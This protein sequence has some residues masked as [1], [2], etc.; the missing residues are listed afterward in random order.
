[1]KRTIISL[2]FAFMLMLSFSACDDADVSGD[3]SESS[4]QKIS[5]E[6]IY[7]ALMKASEIEST[8]CV[9]TE[10]S[11]NH[12]TVTQRNAD[13]TTDYAE[14]TT[15]KKETTYFDG[16]NLKSITERT[17]YGVTETELTW[18]IKT[19]TGYTMYFISGDDY[20]YSEITNLEIADIGFIAW[21]L[22][23]ILFD[24]ESVTVVEN[25]DEVVYSYNYTIE[26]PFP[27]EGTDRVIVKNGTIIRTEEDMTFATT[28]PRGTQTT[29]STSH[30]TQEIE[31]TDVE[32]ITAPEDWDYENAV[33]MD[34]ADIQDYFVDAFEDVFG[35]S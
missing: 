13:G 16:Q 3:S 20:T 34:W 18:V 24:L 25:G 1:M 17:K 9:F 5:S 6:D 4:T 26:G 22:G 23:D 8:P 32:T 19:E 28:D 21:E 33:K 15:Q 35:D 11:T 12:I 31:Y 29:V 14:T 30:D 27:G 2:I 10:T 7:E